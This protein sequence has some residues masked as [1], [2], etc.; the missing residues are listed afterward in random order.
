MGLCERQ[1]CVC[2]RKAITTLE[3][4]PLPFKLDVLT[5]KFSLLIHCL[6]V[7]LTSQTLGLSVHYWCTL[8][9]AVMLLWVFVLV[10]RY[11]CTQTQSYNSSKW[12]RSMKQ[13]GLMYSFASFNRW[14]RAKKF[15]CMLLA[16]HCALIHMKGVSPQDASVLPIVIH[17]SWQS[18][19]AGWLKLAP[20]LNQQH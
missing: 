4:G 9:S 2:H 3:S 6:P 20:T 14:I 11:R 13:P 1:C 7:I 17:W 5:S 10:H 8:S 18:T 16:Y 19:P 12:M 15:K